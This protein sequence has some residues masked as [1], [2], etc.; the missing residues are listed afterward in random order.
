MQIPFRPM[1]Y[2]TTKQI[3]E[4]IGV[5]TCRVRQIAADRGIASVKVGATLLWPRE[6]LKRFKRRGPGRPVPQK[7]K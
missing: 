5:T 2:V 6:S 3:A 7:G 4:A 1:N